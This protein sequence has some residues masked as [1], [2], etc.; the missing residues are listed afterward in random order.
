M[1]DKQGSILRIETTINDPM[2]FKVFRPKE[3]GPKEERSWRYMRKGIAD[4]YRRAQISQSSNNRYIEALS[5]L[6]TDNSLYDLVTPVCKPVVWKSK[7]VRAL[8]PWSNEDRDLLKAVSHGEFCING[9]R[10]R[11]LRNIL[12]SGSYQSV[13]ER[14][15]ATSRITRRIRLLRAHGIIKKVTRT[16]RYVLTNK[17]NKVIKAILEYQQFSL[18]QLDKIAA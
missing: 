13:E 11:D 10:N 4:I 7:R 15:H 3:G 8:H 16:H 18:S 12:K 5:A 1:Y 9:F 6:D 17:G 2:D 14:K